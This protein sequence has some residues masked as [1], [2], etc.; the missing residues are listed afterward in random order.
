MSKNHTSTAYDWRQGGIQIKK[1]HK[2]E[3][4]KDLG[5]PA[6]HKIPAEKLAKA[7]KSKDPA[8]KKRAVFAENA[9]KWGK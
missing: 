5:V 3:L 9:K 1:S 8:V 7:A 6:G 2:G 4:H